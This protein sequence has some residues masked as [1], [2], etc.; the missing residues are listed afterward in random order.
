MSLPI[1][2][3]LPAILFD[4]GG[5]YI[6]SAVSKNC[7]NATQSSL[8]YYEKKAIRNFLDGIPDNLVWRELFLHIER[9]VAS[10]S[11]EV[12]LAAPIVVSFAGPIDAAETIVSASSILGR[13]IEFPDVRAILAEETR[14]SVFLLN[15]MSAATWYISSVSSFCRFMVITVSSG[16]GC[17]LFDRQS[18]HGVA[19][20]ETYAGEIGHIVVDHDPGALI[21]DCGGTGHLQAIA[22]GR[23][24]ERMASRH[25]MRDLTGFG[26]SLCSVKF[27]A[28]EKRIT[29]EEHLVPAAVEGDAWAL[30]VIRECTVYLARVLATIT[31][32]SGL[33]KIIV[34]GGLAQSLGQVYLDILLG[35]MRDNDFVLF[36]FNL[37][38]LQMCPPGDEISLVGAAIYANR[39]LGVE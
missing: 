6:R 39:R 28:S 25:A 24:I 27:G 21:C 2:G 3:Q 35:A 17:K 20:R 16:I 26:A 36:P 4:I 23:G 5:T 8:L 18:F 32:A 33:E 30:N 15:D 19:D 9:Y 34:T 38:L 13:A 10:V 31:I 1:G 22:S 14:R 37:N 12:G 7:C 11:D 29:N